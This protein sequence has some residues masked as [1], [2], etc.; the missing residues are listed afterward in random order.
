[1][2][3]PESVDAKWNSFP[4]TRRT[5]VLGV[6]RPVQSRAAH[7]SF[8]LSRTPALQHRKLILI[9]HSYQHKAMYPILSSIPGYGQM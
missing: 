3:I 5:Q 9:H 1:M 8:Q 6:M 4:S 7:E 2:E